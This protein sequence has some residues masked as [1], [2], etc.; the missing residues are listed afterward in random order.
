MKSSSISPPTV[1]R[2]YREVSVPAAVHMDLSDDQLPGRPIT[3]SPEEKQHAKENE[4]DGE[5]RSESMADVLVIQQVSSSTIS[6]PSLVEEVPQDLEEQS[7][8]SRYQGLSPHRYIWHDKPEEESVV[9]DEPYIRG[10]FNLRNPNIPYKITQVLKPNSRPTSSASDDRQPKAAKTTKRNTIVS[11]YELD[12][13]H[14][15]YST[16]SVV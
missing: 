7:Q 14:P 8:I 2:L 9:D 16:S 10:G 4:T 12:T 15:H 1:E 3:H 11:T 5:Q 6:I 13:K